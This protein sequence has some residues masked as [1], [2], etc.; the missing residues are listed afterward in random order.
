MSIRMMPISFV[1]SRFPRLVRELAAKLDKQVELKTVGEGTELDK[2]LIEKVADPLTHLVR[3]A[4]DHGIEPPAIR[5][6]AGKP[7]RGT[8][9]LRAFHQGGNIVIEV[10]DDGAGLNREKILQKARSQGLPAA[11]SMSEQEVWQLIFE[12]GFS[13]AEVV[14][15][16]SGRGVG[17]DVVRRN[18]QG[19]GGSVEIESR[20][21]VGTRMLIRLPLTLAILDGLSVAIGDQIYI[22][23][24]TYIV[25]SLQPRL[26][27]IKTVQNGGRVIHVRGEYLPIISAHEVFNVNPRPADMSMGIIVI[28]ESDGNKRALHVDELLGQHQ[29]VIKSLETNYRKVHG[30]SGATIMGDGRVALILD[31]G[32]LIRGRRAELRAV[33]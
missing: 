33:A 5:S 28:V 15:D 2:G 13:T 25:E 27:D 7:P 24:L 14:T 26:E 31:V 17:M 3:N 16:V 9:S 11:D 4:I 1:F 18:I 29:V 10:S 21:G 8:I 12:P 19:M 22:V 32:S 20:L 6:A 23:P 30:V